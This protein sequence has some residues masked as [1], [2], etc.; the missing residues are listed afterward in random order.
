LHFQTDKAVLTEASRAMLPE[1]LAAVR[2]RAP[3]EITVF[4]HA[5]A[6]GSGAHNMRLSAE[7]AQVVADWLR[8]QD[9]LFEDID[10]QYFGETRPAVKT[11]PG[12]P[13]PANRRA[14][15]MIL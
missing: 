4:G 8:R 7:R 9:P 2:Q 3:T 15:I 5:D 12:V 14:E 13:E 6:T 1:I 10:V 11:A